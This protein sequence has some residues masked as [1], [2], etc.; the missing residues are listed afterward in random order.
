MKKPLLII[1]VFVA[2]GSMG[3]YLPNAIFTSTSKI[4]TENAKLRCFSTSAVTSQIG[5]WV[6]IANISGGSCTI[7]FTSGIFSAAPYCQATFISGT[8]GSSYTLRVNTSSATSGTVAQTLNGGGDAT[9]INF[10]LSCT[11]AD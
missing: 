10:F 8:T 7:T 1:L 11:G 4:R 2:V 6:S 9:D 3:A 5:S